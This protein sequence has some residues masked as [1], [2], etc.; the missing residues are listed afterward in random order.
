MSFSKTY[1]KQFIIQI[2]IV[3]FATTVSAQNLHGDTLV[4]GGHDKFWLSEEL[5]FGNG[6]MPDG[7]YNYIYEAP[8]ALQKLVKDHKKRL[9]MPRY[10]GYKSKI[11]KFEKEIGRSKKDDNYSIVVLETA[12]GNRFWCDVANAAANHEILSKEA[13]KN[14]T[15]NNT[16]S[17]NKEIKPEVT[18]KHTKT[19]TTKKSV[20]VF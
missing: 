7:S 14:V 17:T 8:N 18:N 20:T 3:L 10:K 2:I 1:Y 5:V 12:D 11:V 15:Q 6:T 19:T 4:L 13:E 9:L 16:N